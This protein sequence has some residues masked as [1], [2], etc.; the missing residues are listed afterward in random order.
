MSKPN[1][2]PESKTL[3]TLQFLNDGQTPADIV[4]RYEKTFTKVAKIRELNDQTKHMD[5]SS[6]AFQKLDQERN[7]LRA[8][9][10]E[11]RSVD[12]ERILKENEIGRAWF[13]EPSIPDLP[14][15][16]EA[17]REGKFVSIIPG[18]ELDSLTADSTI[19]KEENEHM[20]ATKGYKTSLIN[21]N[22]MFLKPETLAVLDLLNHEWKK[23][24]EDR[25][26][27]LA[28]SVALMVTSTTRPVSRQRQLQEEQ[29]VPAAEGDRSTHTLGEAFD[30]GPEGMIKWGSQKAIELLIELLME[31]EKEGYVQVLYETGIMA[32]HVTRNPKFKIVDNKFVPV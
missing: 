28:E 31:W 21:K 14:A 5:E 12:T 7:K 23:R 15:L 3:N 26:P 19:S 17:A 4:A 30:V 29:G 9:L 10:H 1:Q 8:E 22:E 13:D 24:L 11:I 6:E 16:I 25:L 18:L 20:L 27:D 32:I 2:S